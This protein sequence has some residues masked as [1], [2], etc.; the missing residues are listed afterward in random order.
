M[1]DI[2]IYDGGSSDKTT[3]DTSQPNNYVL[4]IE[5]SLDLDFKA[6]VLI[7]VLHGF[8]LYDAEV[9]TQ[10]WVW[11]GQISGQSDNQTINHLYVYG[12]GPTCVLLNQLYHNFNLGYKLLRY[13]RE[14]SVFFFIS[15]WKDNKDD[16]ITI[17]AKKR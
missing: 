3:S 1:D 9:T 16:N 5:M 14:E 12:S 17:S 10:P 8:Q 7:F 13:S 4:W 6:K 11:M 15:D 2:T